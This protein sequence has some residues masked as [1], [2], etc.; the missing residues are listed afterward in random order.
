MRKKYLAEFRLKL[1]MEHSNGNSIAGL[2]KKHKVPRTLLTKW[3]GH[4]K[5]LGVD[6]LLPKLHRHYST[7]FKLAAIQSYRNKELSLRDCCL[8][9]NIPSDSTLLSWLMK[10]E[11]Y[12]VDGFGEQH[13]RPRVMNRPPSKKKS[14]P[15][16]RIEELE[17]EILY[18]KA[19]NELLKKLDAL[20]RPKQAQ[21]KKR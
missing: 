14:I 10:Y 13:G 16:T 8:H 21:N 11:K 5:S 1:V 19:E 9:Y 7:E 20:A 12:G 17:K 6:G 18:L 2:S 3:I 4:Y 15:L